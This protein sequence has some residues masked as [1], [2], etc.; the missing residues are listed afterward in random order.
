MLYLYNR[1]KYYNRRLI[2]M[3]S[4]KVTLEDEKRVK[5]LGFLRNRGTDN[6]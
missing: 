3:A 5:G 6:F 2:I 4:L 1:F